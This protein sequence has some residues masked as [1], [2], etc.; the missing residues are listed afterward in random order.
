MSTT[1]T[2]WHNQMNGSDVQQQWLTQKDA[3]TYTL[4]HYTASWGGGDAQ[5]WSIKLTPAEAEIVAA[6]HRRDHPGD[7]KMHDEDNQVY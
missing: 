2:K 6:L 5:E 3:D 1:V 4:T 7:M